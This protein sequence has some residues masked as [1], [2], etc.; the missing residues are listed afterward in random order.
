MGFKRDK[1]YRLI[2]D[3]GEELGPSSGEPGLEVRV[4]PTS[5]RNYLIAE[6]M[7]ARDPDASMMTS[8]SWSMRR[9]S[10]RDAPSPTSF[11][12]HSGRT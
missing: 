6:R 12:A 7:I 10:A 9:W 11:V 2:W 4:R 5:L 8:P 3:E 1:V